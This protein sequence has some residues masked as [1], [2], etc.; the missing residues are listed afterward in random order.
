LTNLIIFNIIGVGFGFVPWQI[1]W[2]H[3]FQEFAHEYGRLRAL[4]DQKSAK[5]I[6]PEL[7]ILA[8]ALRERAEYFSLAHLF[9]MDL[10]TQF[11][12]LHDEPGIFLT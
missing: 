11:P 8:S 3:V 1:V 4:G 6:L 2:L 10:R 12:S 5:I 7:R 9:L